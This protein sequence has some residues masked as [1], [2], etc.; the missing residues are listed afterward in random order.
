MPFD[1]LLQLV[2]SIYPTSFS[3]ELQVS[4]WIARHMKNSLMI[5]GTCTLIF[6]SDAPFGPTT[7][8]EITHAIRD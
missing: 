5:L 4:R 1:A 3:H 2:L 7:C 6:F 8:G